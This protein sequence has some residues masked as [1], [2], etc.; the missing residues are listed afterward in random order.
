MKI[1]EQ[2]DDALDCPKCSAAPD[3]SNYLHH[4]RINIFN[5]DREDSETGTQVAVDGYLI[6]QRESMR[7]NPSSRRDGLTIA[8]T[9]ENCAA[10]LS[11]AIVQHKGQTFIY[12]EE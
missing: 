2:I 5:R 7:G 11:L 3:D 6:G 1:D 12:W 4:G 9:C 10:Q 8:F